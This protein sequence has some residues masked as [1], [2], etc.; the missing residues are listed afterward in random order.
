[1]GVRL[2]PPCSLGISQWRYRLAMAQVRWFGLATW[3]S[4]GTK[5]VFGSHRRSS[6]VGAAD[7][8][9]SEKRGTQEGAHRGCI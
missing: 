5:A 4:R 8:A 1:M 7:L 2:F 6:G 3:G 9:G